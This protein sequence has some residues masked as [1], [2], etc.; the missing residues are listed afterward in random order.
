MMGTDGKK[1]PMSKRIMALLG[2]HGALLLY[3]FTGIL[4]K[5]AA[6]YEVLSLPWISY[7]IGVV[8]LLGIYAIAWQQVIKHLPL[9]TAF[10]N[11]AITVLWGM[12]WGLLIFGEEINAYK[13]IVAAGVILFVKADG[14]DASKVDPSR[15]L[16]GEDL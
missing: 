6:E 16:A 9:T 12:I 2:L 3:S 7:Y 13:I 10:A 11:K 1:N 5:F 15:E 4:G 14:E 8:F